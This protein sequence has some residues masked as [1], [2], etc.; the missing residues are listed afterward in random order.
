MN[1]QR[2]VDT[3][4]MLAVDMVE[5]AAS[6]HPGLPLGAAPMAYALWTRHLRFN[7]LDPAWPNRDRFVLSAGHGSALLYSLLHLFGVRELTMEQLQRFR[8][9]GS[10]TPGHPEYRLTPGVEVTTGPLGQGISNAVG[11]A[12]AERHLAARINRPEFPVVDFRTFVIASDGDMMEG[13]SSEASSLAGHLR[14][15]KLV[16]LYD[17]NRI[18]IDGSTSLAF[19]EDVGKRYDAYGWQ[20]LVVEDGNDVDAVDE[21]LTAATL[22]HGRPTLIRVRTTIG[23]GAPDK[24]GTAAVHGSP[25][26]A[27]ELRRTKE[28]Y[29]FDPDR[30]FVVEDDVR[31]AFE[32]FARAGAVDEQRHADLLAEFRR[33]HRDASRDYDAW[34]SGTLPA[35]LSNTRPTFETGTSM[36]TRKASGA[37]LASLTPVIPFL[38]GGSADLTPSNDTKVRSSEDVEPGHYGGRYIHFGVREHAMG[39]IMN[40]MA[41]TGLV[42]Y[43][44]TFLIFSDYMRPAIRLA[45]L[46]GYGSIFVFTHDSIALGEDGPTHQPVEQLASLRAIPNLWVFRPADANETA[47]AWQMA[48]ERRN[49]PTAIALTRQGVP[50]LDGTDGDSARRGGYVLRDVDPE[51]SD[52]DVVLV[53]TGS[54]VHIALDAADILLGNDIHA[55]VVSLP[56]MELLHEQDPEYVMELFPIAVPVVSIEAGVE[57]GW[58]GLSD[59]HVGMSSFGASAPLA[60]VLEHFGITPEHVAGKARELVEEIAQAG[61]ELDWLLG[62]G[63]SEDGE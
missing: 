37:A 2:N 63:Q 9:L 23:Y 25:L 59:L 6:G 55:R 39:A 1:H 24:E 43:G 14:L 7:P 12:L 56:C 35:E 33:D 32:E 17:D 26:G 51:L 44:G 22:E 41:V 52:I 11:I 61:R 30:S 29:G 13:V 57:L 15:G 4:R 28:F 50:V 46:S 58:N 42:P 18:S 27:E 36:A 21:A 34:V 49:A 20:V 38:I 16:V 54:E 5:T 40:G 19:T 31:R 60:D 53:A 62:S 45:A 47:V 10:I 48:V 8:Q 3:I